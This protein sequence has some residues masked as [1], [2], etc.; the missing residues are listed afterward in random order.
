MSAFIEVR[1][2]TGDQSV[3]VEFFLYEP[4]NSV[5]SIEKHLI[6]IEAINKGAFDTYSK[7]QKVMKANI[8]MFIKDLN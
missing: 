4:V 1:N 5:S 7:V 2:V 6:E 8:E 3:S